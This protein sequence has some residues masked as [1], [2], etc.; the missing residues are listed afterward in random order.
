MCNYLYKS[1]RFAG[2]MEFN[3]TVENSSKRKN[4]KKVGIFVRMRLINW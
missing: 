3:G 2:G 1:G 4:N